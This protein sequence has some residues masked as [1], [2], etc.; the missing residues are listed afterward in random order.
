M[1]EDRLSLRITLPQE[2]FLSR[3][4][5]VVPGITAVTGINNVGKTR[6]L[7]R[8]FHIHAWWMQAGS[9]NAA[10]FFPLTVEFTKGPL[11]MSLTVTPDDA[12]RWSFFQ[13]TVH[14]QVEGECV[15]QRNTG[16]PDRFDVRRSDGDVRGYMGGAVSLKALTMELGKELDAVM[17]NFIYVPPQRTVAAET[18]I[19]RDLIPNPDGSNLA[20]ALVTYRNDKDSRFV[21]MQ[22]IMRIMFPEI[23]DILTT[24]SGL[25]TTR[26]MVQDRF[27]DRSVPLSDCGTG[28]AQTLH[29]L[30]LIYLPP[31]TLVG[32]TEHRG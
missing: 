16:N 26:L 18:Q 15:G 21:E 5:D 4:L 3:P 31:T 29:L 32:R 1:K 30:A 10:H 23:E 28:V 8:L 12:E 11:R 17:S 7:K 20:C 19:R 13:R 27:L 25:N 14:G 22:S 24:I 6:L 9:M 2:E